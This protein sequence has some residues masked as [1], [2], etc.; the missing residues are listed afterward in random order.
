MHSN[1]SFRCVFVCVCSKNELLLLLL[2]LCCIPVPLISNKR[3]V[4]MKNRHKTE[5][6]MIFRPRSQSN[7]AYFCIDDF[8]F[9]SCSQSVWLGCAWLCCAVHTTHSEQLDHK[10]SNEKRFAIINPFR[11]KWL[12]WSVMRSCFIIQNSFPYFP[13]NR[14]L[15]FE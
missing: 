11:R 4:G 1:D 8:K 14:H 7:A 13:Q 6:I 2:M 15:T 9:I 5:W 3:A 10:K 12:T